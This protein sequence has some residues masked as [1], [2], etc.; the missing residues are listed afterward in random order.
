LSFLRQS[1]NRYEGS[2]S[3][4]TDEYDTVSRVTHGGAGRRLGGRHQEEDEED[5]EANED[6]NGTDEDGDEE[7]LELRALERR[8]QFQLTSVAQY[9]TTE[10]IAKLQGLLDNVR[11]EINEATSS[12]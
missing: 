4:L 10:E 7:L 11:R 12:G 6:E 2:V 1:K 3:D 9:G 5:E 8:Y